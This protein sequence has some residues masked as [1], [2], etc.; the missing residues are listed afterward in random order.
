PGADGGQATGPAV[1]DN[2]QAS[3]TAG[4]ETSQA[5][6]EAALRAQQGAVAT[7]ALDAGLQ[8]ARENQQANVQQP[9]APAAT[10]PEAAAPQAP[11][12]PGLRFDATLPTGEINAP[13][14]VPGQQ[15]TAPHSGGEHSRHEARTSS[16]STADGG[17][18]VKASSGLESGKGFESASEQGTPGNPAVGRAAQVQTAVSVENIAGHAPVGQATTATGTSATLTATGAESQ[19]PGAPNGQPQDQPNQVINRVVRGLSAMIGQRGG[20]LNMRLQPPEL[21]QLRVQM[22]IARG[23]VTAQFQPASAEVQAILD[24][25]LATLR[26]ALESHGLSVERLSVHSAQQQAGGTAARDAADEQTHQQRNQHDAGEGQSRGR[27]DGQGETTPHRFAFQRD[28]EFEM[29]EPAAAAA[30]A[31]ES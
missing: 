16:G 18:Q 1:T 6:A 27:R 20:V 28:Y 29:P 21:G 19:A 26:T 31:D 4:Q 24:R 11:A 9:T 10:P 12:G 5:A 22:T 3:S 30:G 7:T 2:S 8:G 13:V 14:Q 25:S 23:V 15:D 17:Q